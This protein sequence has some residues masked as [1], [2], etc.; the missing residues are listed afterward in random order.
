[1]DGRDVNKTI[2]PT[3][4][5]KLNEEITNYK[6]F[7]GIGSCNIYIVH[8]RFSKE[9]NGYG[10]KCIATGWMRSRYCSTE[11]LGEKTTGLLPSET[12]R[13][14]LTCFR[15]THRLGDFLLDHLLPG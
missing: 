7:I 3:L 15:D 5:S 11:L 6:G 9:L 12:C 10:E 2:L 8:N 4:W 1:M 14:K 13:L